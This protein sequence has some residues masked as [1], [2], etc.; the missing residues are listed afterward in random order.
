MRKLAWLTAMCCAAV[1]AACSGN[2]PPSW[3]GGSGD[4]DG[5]S[6]SD[7]DSDSDVDSDTDGDTDADTDA[8]TDTDTDTG[9]DD[10][11]EG[12][13]DEDGD[14]RD[15]PCDNCPTFGNPLQEDADSDGVGDACEASW[16]TALLSQVA[17]F[18]PFTSSDGWV[19]D[20]AAWTQGTDTVTGEETPTGGNYKYDVYAIG[21]GNYAVE[22]I[23]DVDMPGTSGGVYAGVVFAYQTELTMTTWWECVYEQNGD[24]ISIWEF[25][26]YSIQNIGQAGVSGSDDDSDW[27]RL[28]V[29]FNGATL[30]CVFEE[31]SGAFGTLTLDDWDVPDDMSGP[32][33][34]RVYNDSAVF[35]S[36]VIYR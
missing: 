17:V 28:R 5:D 19:P 23:W 22:T 10:C 7:S 33:G 12:D 14:G 6:D 3:K 18:V 26:G 2:S 31:E 15:D 36:F 27:R 9:S 1:L 4:S 16:N 34:L 21:S 8:D 32:A 29:F 24:T 20:G 35:R 30:A 11:P 13:H 25:D